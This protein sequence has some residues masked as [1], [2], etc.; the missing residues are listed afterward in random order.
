M[1]GESDPE[2][3][4]TQ[5]GEKSSAKQGTSGDVYEFKDPKSK[6]VIKVTK[7]WQDTLGNDE[8]PV[9]DITISTQ[10]PSKN[11][12]GYTVTFNANGMTFPDGSVTNEVVYNAS[13]EIVSGI[14]MLPSGFAI[15]WYLDEA[16]TKEV[17][18]SAEGV[19]G[20]VAGDITLYAKAKTVVLKGNWQGFTSAIPG[21]ATAVVFTD[22][23]MPTTSKVIDVDADGDGGVVAWMDGTTFKVSAQVKGIK[24]IAPTNC[25]NL[26]F[27]KSKLV[28]IDCSGL[29]TR[30]VTNMDA[31]FCGCS[32]LTS[33][34]ISQWDTS[35]VTSIFR[36]SGN[37]N[38]GLFS[39]CRSLTELKLNGFK[40]V[41]CFAYMFSDCVKL[42]NLDLTLL[43]TSNGKDFKYMFSSCCELTSLDL[44]PLDT[45]NGTRFDHMFENC[46]NLMSLDLSTFDASNGV[47]FEGMFYWCTSLISLDLPQTFDT[48]NGTDFQFMFYNCISLRSL[49]LTPLDMTNCSNSYSMFGDCYR[50]SSL[51]LGNKFDWNVS[52]C[53]LTYGVWYNTAGEAFTSMTIPS[54][55]A[56]TYTRR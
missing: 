24:V 28:K 32:S 43:D 37:D 22:E 39:N 33:I 15:G 18:V 55:V 35:S 12:L 44:T 19:L 17:V 6:G 54:N 26:F 4:H 20:T 10:K 16:C 36:E 51:T 9:P 47:Y 14:Y 3:S 46:R 23:T 56:D 27:L 49:D 25:E 29:D 31:M 8:R 1:K 45:S 7:I 42:K 2:N 11:P 38:Y 48:R 52:D 21:E 53:G 13:G 34:D 5:P 41:S 40:E 50:L 30:N